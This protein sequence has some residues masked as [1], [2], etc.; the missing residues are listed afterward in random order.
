MDI[1]QIRQEIV[2]ID[3][4]V[5]ILDGSLVPY[6][7]FD[8]AAT[9]PALRPVYDAANEFLLDYSSV[10]R[11][12]GYKSR[13][14]S[15]LYEN[16][17]QTALD[18]F[19]ANAGEHVALFGK[20]TTEAINV[21]ANRV[22]LEKDDVIIISLAEHHSNDL[23]WRAKVTATGAKLE[24]IGITPVGHL[25]QEN[26][27]E[28]LKQHAGHV[29]LV[30]ITGASNVTGHLPDIHWFAEQAHEAGAQ[31]LVDAAQ[32]AAHRQIRMGR[33]DEADHL[34]YVAFSGHKMYAPYGTGGLIARRDTFERGEPL[35]RGGGTIDIVTTEDIDWAMPPERHEAGSPNVLG[36]VA[37]AKAMQELQRIGFDNIAAH[38]A[39]LT[40][41]AINQ[42]NG[43][44]RMQIYGDT[45]FATVGERSGVIPF[46]MRKTS[47]YLVAAALGYEHSVGVRNGC[48]CAHPYV[49][50]LLGIDQP[51]MQQ[52]RA[53]MLAGNRT[54][55]PGFTRISFGIYN[56][57]REI[58][59]AVEGLR[60]IAARD[61][62]HY[63]QDPTTG[64]FTPTK[65]KRKKPASSP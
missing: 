1:E 56:T 5:P 6:V 51:T 2:G 21:L 60:A 59:Y 42:L 29:K 47:H 12:T 19:G 48:F 4:Q 61:H 15:E 11:G 62:A 33:L 38:E 7:N 37:V 41:H 49:T 30:A 24:R 3:R 16:A 10:H 25:D 57:I 43:V 58:D 28:L 9:T 26:Y 52:T 45:N 39:Q 34:D 31:I 35:L 63:R 17:R 22:E 8:N 50:R 53:E 46:T 18:F 32:L 65:R 36:A 44:H 20:N 64:E 14:S 54:N 55:M 23:P 13:H 40:A 27:L